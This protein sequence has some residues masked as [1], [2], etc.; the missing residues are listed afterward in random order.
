[1]NN[2][3]TVESYLKSDTFLRR[4]HLGSEWSAIR[5]YVRVLVTKR[6]KA[7]W[8]AELRRHYTD[9]IRWFY[10]YVHYRYGFEAAQKLVRG[11]KLD[12]VSRQNDE[13]EH[14]SHDSDTGNDDLSG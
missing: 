13:I 8:N 4:V 2:Y 6:N 12:G 3:S 7:W 9:G 11:T 1:M 5:S 14:A 10:D